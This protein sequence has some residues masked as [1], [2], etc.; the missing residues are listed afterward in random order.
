MKK[1]EVSKAVLIL[2]AYGNLGCG[3]SQYLEEYGYHVFRHGRG[4]MAQVSAS[5]IAG[6]N[7]L[8]FIDKNKIHV[9]INLVASIDVDR[10]EIDPGYA[11]SGNVEFIS[12]VVRALLSR[13]R[14]DR[15]HL[16]HISTD[17]LYDGL[18]GE[19]NEEKIHLLN[20]YAISKYYGE[21]Y[22]Q[23]I[24]ST[25]LR[26]NFLSRSTKTN[27][28]SLSDWIVDNLRN[29]TGINV[30][31]NIIFS[32]VYFT[33]LCKVIRDCIEKKQLGVFNVGSRGGMSKASFAFRLADILGYNVK[34]LNSVEYQGDPNG[35]LRPMNMQMNS[36]K[37]ENLFGYELPAL[38][39][40]IELLAKDY[41]V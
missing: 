25:I 10:C 27:T 1:Y 16:I 23:K 39:S 40:E 37:Y 7:F 9:I 11:F 31:N 4:L 36:H 24:N 2:G 30:F 29:N 19:S 38:E 18:T 8:K 3:L 13:C 32:P 15:P 5:E 6:Y 34:L 35:A 33:T 12:N 28:M 41:L 14:D 20:S 21:L 26:T 22:A 17:H